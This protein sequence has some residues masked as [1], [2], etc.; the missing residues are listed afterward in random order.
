[1]SDIIRKTLINELTTP[2][3]GELAQFAEAVASRL[4]RPPLGVLFYGSVLRKVDPEGIVDFY[5]ITDRPESLGGHALARMANRLL[6]PNVY[7]MEHEVEGRTIR[8][9]VAFLSIAQFL[10]RS[11]LFTVDT[12]IWARFCQPV[13]LVWVRDAG[14]ADRLLQAISQC[15]VTASCWAALLGPEQGRADVY[16]HDLFAHTYAAELR[17]EKKGRSHNLLAGREER[18]ET[19]LKAAWR[20]ASLSYAAQGDVL[21]PQLTASARDKATRDWGR[22]KAF[23]KPLNVARLIKAAFTFRDGVSYLL[24]KIQR[25]TGQTIHVSVF[26]KRH[27][28]LTL[29]LFLWRARHLRSGRS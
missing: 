5:V 6:P 1:M 10:G 28:I 3:A 15:V 7:Y 19:L 12:T 14:S 22:V 17:V 9:K 25:H 27:P 23:G 13:R 18:Y 20:Q 16:W 29:P 21:L 24:W 26:E 4:R 2:V 11:T 8:A